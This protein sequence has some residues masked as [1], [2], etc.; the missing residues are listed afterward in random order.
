MQTLVTGGAGFI[1]SHLVDALLARGDRAALQPHHAAAGVGT[2]V[3][4]PVPINRQPAF[5]N[6]PA[7][8]CRCADDV[9]ARVLSLPIHPALDGSAVAAIAAA[10]QQW[11]VR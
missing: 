10:I 7:A 1:G 4:Y 8:A 6:L 9:S 11:Q 2:L 5:A 3:H